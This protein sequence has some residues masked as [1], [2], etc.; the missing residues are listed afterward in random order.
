MKCVM[1]RDAKSLGIFVDLVEDC[2]ELVWFINFVHGVQ[3]Q[4][5]AFN[6]S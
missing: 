2:V 1:S 3:L 5:T 4:R 6:T